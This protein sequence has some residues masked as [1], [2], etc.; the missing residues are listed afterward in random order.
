MGPVL[1]ASPMVLSTSIGSHIMVHLSDYGSLVKCYV[2][3][4]RGPDQALHAQYPELREQ[5]GLY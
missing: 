2:M 5:T 1:T 3:C 4:R